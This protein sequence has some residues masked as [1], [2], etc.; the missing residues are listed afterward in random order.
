MRPYDKRLL[1]A[2]KTVENPTVGHML[3]RVCL[4]ANIPVTHVAHALEVT[5][6]T[7]H[8]WY[9]G[10]EIR[11]SNRQMITL[12][13][14]YILRDTVSGRLPAKSLEDATAYI[15]DLTGVPMK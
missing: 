14:E 8:L 13:M 12:F 3:A 7:V 6:M 2:I 5:R 10:G 4:T 15:V 11:R 1:E 9:R